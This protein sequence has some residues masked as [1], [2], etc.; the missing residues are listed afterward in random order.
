MDVTTIVIIAVEALI[1]IVTLLSGGISLL[2]WDAIKTEK[3]DRKSATDALWDKYND[4]AKIITK[5]EKNIVKIAAKTKV[6]IED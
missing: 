6:D 5:N 2:V 4:D 3:V 1:A